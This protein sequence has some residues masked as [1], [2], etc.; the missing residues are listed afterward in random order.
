[1]AVCK[2][3]SVLGNVFLQVLRSFHIP[4]KTDIDSVRFLS[5]IEWC[6]VLNHLPTEIKSSIKLIRDGI[7][8]SARDN[9]ANWKTSSGGFMSCNLKKKT[10]YHPRNLNYKK[11]AVKQP[12]KIPKR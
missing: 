7:L 1:M 10:N 6:L 8:A 9:E 4:T 3:S 5:S 2:I 12:L 11:K